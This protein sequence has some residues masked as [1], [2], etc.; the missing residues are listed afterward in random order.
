MIDLDIMFFLHFIRTGLF[1]N[2]MMDGIGVLTDKKGNTREVYMRN[3]L[4]VCD[5][6]GKLMFINTILLYN[7]FFQFVFNNIIF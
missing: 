3:N 6:S 7:I 4:V 2:G 5:R 1:K